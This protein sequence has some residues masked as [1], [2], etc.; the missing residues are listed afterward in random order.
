MISKNKN[1]RGISQLAPLSRQGTNIFDLN[2]TLDDSSPSQWHALNNADQKSQSTA[3]YRF[4]SNNDKSLDLTLSG[5]MV[6]PCVIVLTYEELQ[7][8]PK[9]L[10]AMAVEYNPSMHEV[11]VDIPEKCLRSIL[12]F[13][14]HGYWPSPYLVINKGMFDIPKISEIDSLKKLCEYL[15]LPCIEENTMDDEEYD[16]D[17]FM[18]VGREI[19]AYDWDMI[20]EEILAKSETLQRKQEQDL[21]DDHER[22]RGDDQPCK[23]RTFFY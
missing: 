5:L 2:L 21:E 14:Q 18:E 13:Y 23:R 3:M 22:R 11:L 15:N 7:K 6:L 20:Q 9:S 1:R 8:Y 19:H 17:D 12:H 16:S 4:V 10:F